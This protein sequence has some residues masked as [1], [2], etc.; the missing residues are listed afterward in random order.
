MYS[1]WHI[2]L[3]NPNYLAS[4]HQMTFKKKYSTLTQKK[5][6]RKEEIFKKIRVLVVVSCNLTSSTISCQLFW[7]ECYKL[8]LWFKYMLTPLEVIMSCCHLHMYLFKT[9]IKLELFLYFIRGYWHYNYLSGVIQKHPKWFC[10]VIGL[11]FYMVPYPFCSF[12][13]LFL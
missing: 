4:G 5:T 9:Y 10:F 11:Y 1:H 12:S 13:F 3:E 7:F 2:W 8:W 6:N